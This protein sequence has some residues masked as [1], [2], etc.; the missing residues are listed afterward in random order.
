M[1]SA[2]RSLL[3]P[4]PCTPSRLSRPSAPLPRRAHN[5]RAATPAPAPS[6]AL[7]T[8]SRGGRTC[9]DASVPAPPFCESHPPLSNRVRSR[10]TPP[11]GPHKF[12]QRHTHPHD[13]RGSST[14]YRCPSTRPVPPA[15]SSPDSCGSLIACRQRNKRKYCGAERNHRIV[16][17]HR[18]SNHS[19]RRVIAHHDMR[20][21]I[22]LAC[23]LKRRPRTG[24]RPRPPLPLNSRMIHTDRAGDGH[25]KDGQ[26]RDR[27]TQ[28]GADHFRGNCPAAKDSDRRRRDVGPALPV[29]DFT[30]RV[31]ADV[32][33][34]ERA[35][36]EGQRQYPSGEGH[37]LPPRPAPPAN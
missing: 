17:G 10:R 16:S 11:T 1:R 25:Q 24:A 21:E 27:P 18:N 28:L 30:R 5:R 15:S 2:H 8:R 37:Q 19:P 20:F 12:A 26:D 9:A 35:Q 14:R 13:P 6:A 33:K 32:L 29:A 23:E 22:E 3:P 4:R 36:N 31:T 7:G 34:P